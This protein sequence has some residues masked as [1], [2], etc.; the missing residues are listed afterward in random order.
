MTK[1]V[2][3]IRPA[4]ISTETGTRLDEYRRFQHVVR[5]VYTPSFDPAN[6]GTGQLRSRTFTRTKAEFL[7]FATFDDAALCVLRQQIRFAQ[8]RDTREYSLDAVGSETYR[9]IAREVAESLSS[10]CPRKGCVRS[11]RSPEETSDS[12]KKV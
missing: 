3:G 4:M 1:E 7:A 10:C 8:G 6:L 12:I 11:L 2:S 5:N 9:K